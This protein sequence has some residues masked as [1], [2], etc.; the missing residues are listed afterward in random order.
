[1]FKNFL[2]GG[3]DIPIKRTIVEKL[4]EIEEGIKVHH[5]HKLGGAKKKKK[6]RKLL[7]ENIGGKLLDKIFAS[8]EKL[9]FTEDLITSVKKAFSTM[10][11]K[12]IANKLLNCVLLDKPNTELKAYLK[13]VAPVPVDEVTPSSRDSTSKGRSGTKNS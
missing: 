1:M 10:S 13:S 8:H 11:V 9:G 5:F 2:S 12:G 4:S 7:I 3:I 6:A